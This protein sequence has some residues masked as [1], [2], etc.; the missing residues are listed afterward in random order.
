LD[1][2]VTKYEAI[3]YDAIE[4]SKVE[5]HL[6]D[7]S[8]YKQ[9]MIEASNYLSVSAIN[10][11]IPSAEKYALMAEKDALINEKLNILQ[12]RSWKLTALYRKLGKVIINIFD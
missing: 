7:T 5:K 1:D 12:S 3:Y 2:S 10:I 11:K 9:M 6:I 8:S 4:L